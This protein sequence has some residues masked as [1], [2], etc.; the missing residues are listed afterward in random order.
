MTNL[1][2]LRDFEQGVLFLHDDIGILRNVVTQS[3]K[4]VRSR[5]RLTHNENRI[6]KMLISTVQP[7]DQDFKFYKFKTSYVVKVLGLRVKAIIVP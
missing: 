5:Y 4:L 1:A 2:E 7:N 6:V 3:N